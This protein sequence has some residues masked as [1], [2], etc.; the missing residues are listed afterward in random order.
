[1]SF[2]KWA[3]VAT[4][5]SF[6]M[7]AVAETL[8]FAHFVAPTHTLTEAIIT[9]LAEAI[10]PSGLQVEI[11]PAGKLGAGPAEQYVRVVQGVADI[12]WGLPG[13]TSSQFPQTML[14]EAQDISVAE[15]RFLAALVGNKQNGLFFAGDIGQRIFQPPFSWKTLGIDVRGR[16][17]TLR[18]NYRTSHQI[19]AQADKLLPE[20]LSDVDGNSES[21]RGTVSIFD[22]PAPLVQ[23]CKDHDDETERVAAWLHDRISEG[24]QPEEIAV[25]V[26]SQA[27]LSRARE[28]V[29]SA[30][31]KC[32]ELDDS[33]AV[34]A[35]VVSICVM[36]LAKG[37]EFRAVAVIACDDEVIPQA[38][39]IAAIADEADLE[40]IYETERHLLYVACTRA[41]DYLLLTGIA[42]MS[43]FIDDLSSH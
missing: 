42:P 32:I 33:V 29:K 8:K 28:A 12:V 16:S 4:A 13:Y 1:M 40:A 30:G 23:S 19:R 39:R 7:P 21:R 20:T 9:P 17:S 22:G 26:R 25:F 10:A 36:H 2:P 35:G 31:L 34:S 15:A 37:L 3:A 11:Y 6:A 5:L 24:L 41:R 14:D 43:E 27:E 18:I 38:E